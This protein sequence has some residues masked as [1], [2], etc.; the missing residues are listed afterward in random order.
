ME[1]GQSQEK[2]VVSD[3]PESLQTEQK[4][5]AFIDHMERQCF[6]NYANVHVDQIGRFN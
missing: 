5:G 4:A 6:S 3:A 1:D 2:Q